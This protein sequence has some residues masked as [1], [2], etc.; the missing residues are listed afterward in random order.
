MKYY[1]VGDET[2]TY[3]VAP[4]ASNAANF[5]DF[6]TGMFVN[7]FVF[8]EGLGGDGGVAMAD[9]PIGSL[10]IGGACV[11]EAIGMMVSAD[12]MFLLRCISNPPIYK[13]K[14]ISWLDDL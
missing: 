3:P 1:T 8:W 11:G 14:K 4:E 2:R 6:S 9:S 13:R 5:F 10:G 7:G 12:L